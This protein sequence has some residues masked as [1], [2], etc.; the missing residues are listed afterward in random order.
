MKQL[1]DLFHS[2]QLDDDNAT[3]SLKQHYVE[4]GILCDL[5]PPPPMVSECNTTV[6]NTNPRSEIICQT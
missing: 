1:I 6:V 2:D 5:V 4:T 3:T